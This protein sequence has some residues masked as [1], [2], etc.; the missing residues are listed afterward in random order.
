MTS[1]KLWACD[2][3]TLLKWILEDEKKGRIFGIEKDL[4]FV[5]R[6]T[7]AFRMRRYGQ[8]LE[9]PVGVAAGPHTQLSQNLIAAWLTGGRYMELKTIQI[10][11]ELEVTKPC[12]DMGD[13]GYNCE[14]SQEL[15][16]D[17]SFDEYLNAW[18]VLHI[19][20]DKFGWGEHDEPGFIFNMSVGYNLEGILS[21]TVQ[22]FLDRMADCGKEKAEKIEKIATFYPRVRD[23]NISDCMSDNVTVSTMHGCPPDEVEKIGRYFV[24]ERK[25]HTTIK[26]NPTLLGDDGVRGIL[27]E[28]LGFKTQVPDLAFDHDLKYPDGVALIRSLLDS[29]RKVGVEF[30]IKLTNTLE[31][32]NEDQDL[33][34]NEKMVYMSGRSLHPISINLARRLQDEFQGELDI[35]FSA[36]TSYEN[37][38]S[39]LACNLKPITTCSDILRPGGYG[40]LSQYLEKLSE[41]ISGAGARNIDDFVVAESGKAQDVKQAGWANLKKYAGTVV[42]DG[43]YKKENYP[44][45]NIKTETELGPFDCIQAPCMATCSA[46]QDIPSYLYYTAKGD[47]EKAR[48]VILETNPFP[49][50]QGMV[51]DHLCQSKCTRINYDDPILIREIKR[52]VIQNTDEKSHVIPASANGIK[53]GI[54]GAGPSGLS[55]AYFLAQQGYDVEIFEGKKIAGGW[56]AD[57][58][59]TF[60]L[61][62]D[63]IK[64][65]IDAILSLGVKIHYSTEID[66]TKFEKMTK[67]F[68]YIYVAVGAQEG[69]KL[70][71]P[72]EDA[73]GVMDNLDFLSAVRRGETID[74]GKKVVIIGG[75][76]SAMDAARTAKRLVGPGGEVNLIYRRTREEMPAALEEVQGMLD[77]E[78]N[79]IELTA[80]ECMLVQDGKVTSNRCFQ[81]KLG[82]KDDSGRPR[83]IRIEGSEFDLEADSVISAIGQR[84][85]ADFFPEG[86][87]EIDPISHETQIKNVF[88]GGDATRGASTLINAIGDGKNVAESITKRAVKESK[89]GEGLL[90]KSVDPEE[91]RKAKGRR[92]PG[93]L[94]PEIGFDERS[95]FKMVINTLDEATAKAE[96]ARCLQCDEICS[97]CVSVCPNRANMEFQMEPVSFKIQQAVPGTDG[98][99]II[100]LETGKITQQ[101]QILNLGDCCNECG[102]CATF[103][104]TNGAPY[105]DKPKFHLTSE[106]YKTAD[107]GYYFSATDRLEFK[108]DQKHAQLEIQV[109]G[110]VFENEIFKAFLNN[111]YSARQVEFKNGEQQ[112][113]SLLEAVH[114]A[115]LFKAVNGLA[116]L[117]HN[118]Q[119]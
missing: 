58:I 103:C 6:A 91:L 74:L 80:P 32:T 116:P 16:L 106:S 97:V 94:T 48:K 46:S 114:M 79:L 77:E 36:G 118:D 29:A 3:E 90:A 30:N 38:A 67:D 63:S 51:C 115:I 47:Y 31:T 70:G 42:E 7:D 99:Q 81:M 2:I 25:L 104:P 68:D 13:E 86:K 15:K 110:F 92:Q 93:T 8:L 11:D 27:N 64:K 65:D 24:E 54:I 55:C 69:V 40:R 75:G 76:N 101:Y 33:P 34:D 39:V 28:K 98:A 19:L 84:V 5:P 105:Q 112:T 96:A 113:V 111:D 78:V 88:A 9:T 100:D 83:P 21:P 107:Y 12:I 117:N 52:F 43:N 85:N 119:A 62:D 22:K 45:D 71:V 61:D 66:Q 35:S 26:L 49:N 89:I 17:E 23:I 72:G 37:V 41:A 14:W 60:R 82:E 50:I 87:L 108:K 73:E 56:A 59:P 53:V 10:L 20:K 1:D 57:A 102:N 95:G 109:D 44:Y 4:F 18:I